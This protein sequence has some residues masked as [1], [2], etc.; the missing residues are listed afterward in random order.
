MPNRSLPLVCAAL[1]AIA[2]GAPS[3]VAAASRTCWLQRLPGLV[4]DAIAQETMTFENMPAESAAAA[5]RRRT[6]TRTRGAVP[7]VAPEAPEAPIPPV[8]RAG[9]VVRIG[10]DIHIEEN[11]VV[12]GDVFALQGDIRV[13]GHVK[14]NVATTG[15]DVHLGSTA[16]VDGD[17]MC[18]GGALTEDPG[19]D[20]GGQRVT[21]LRGPRVQDRIK[22]RIEDR[23]EHRWDGERSGKGVGFSIS[24]MISTLLVGWLFA[25]FVPGRTSVALATLRNEPG[26]SLMVGFVIV[27]LLLPSL[28]ALLLAFIVLL[29]TIVGI[30]IAVLLLPAY[31]L[32]LAI[33]FLWGFTLGATVVGDRFGSSLGGQGSLVR[34]TVRGVLLVSG[35]LVASAILHF[36]PFFGWFAGLLWVLGFVTFGLATL[37]GAGALVRS[38]FGQGPGGRWWPPFPRPT[39]Q[40]PTSPTMPAAPAAPMATGAPASPS[41]PPVA[42]PTEG[43]T[44]TASYMP[45]ESPGPTEPGSTA[46]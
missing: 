26:G 6:G 9:D 30:P 24:W 38:K 42:P 4:S 13:D 41:P 27:L 5:E 29:I 37:G 10:S 45:P 15:G 19:A 8:S 20:V 32:A 31:A 28:V 2:L 35:L 17:V 46:L 23:I 12:D 40:S 11:Q 22:Q 33:L 36:L 18:I 1:A 43:T 14:G 16:R 44:S 21:A 39:P 25:R 34:S 7:P 3:P